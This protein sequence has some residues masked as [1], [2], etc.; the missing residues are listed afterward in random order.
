M[1]S[2]STVGIYYLFVNVVFSGE[3]VDLRFN[4]V[5]NNGRQ[6]VKNVVFSG[7]YCSW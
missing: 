2:I 1:V 7:E 3:Q 6:Y 5:I 4:I